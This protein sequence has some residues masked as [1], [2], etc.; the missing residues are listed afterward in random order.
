MVWD[1]QPRILETENSFDGGI[2]WNYL[3]TYLLK[4]LQVVKY[5]V[6]YLK[7][8]QLLQKCQ[9]SM[10][11][12]KVTFLC[13]FHKCFSILLAIASF[14]SHSLLSF[15]FSTSPAWNGAALGLFWLVEHKWFLWKPFIWLASTEKAAIFS[16]WE[17][18]L[19]FFFNS[20]FF[21]D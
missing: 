18:K 7:V 4:G 6:E 17:P 5:V 9:M 15:P 12:E 1:V 11:R 19:Y 3:K 16:A 14:W 21:L 2:I 8:D 10:Q 13:F 20:S